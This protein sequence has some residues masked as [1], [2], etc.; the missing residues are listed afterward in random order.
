MHIY[1]L[2]DEKDEP[3]AELTLID[4]VNTIHNAG[5]FKV[6]KI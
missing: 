6:S 4:N 3:G 2:R 1:R 5:G